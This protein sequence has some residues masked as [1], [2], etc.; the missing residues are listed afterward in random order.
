MLTFNPPPPLDWSTVLFMATNICGAAIDRHLSCLLF[1]IICISALFMC[2]EREEL[3]RGLGGGNILSDR[4]E[5]QTLSRCL[6]GSEVQVSVQ[7]DQFRALSWSRIRLSGSHV[8][9]L[10]DPLLIIKKANQHLHIL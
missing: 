3:R 1:L 9:V 7:Q 10:A 6:R 5:S 8:V 4:E 2:R